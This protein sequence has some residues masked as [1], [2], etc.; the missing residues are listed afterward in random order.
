MAAPRDA[1][2]VLTAVNAVSTKPIAVFESALVEI[3]RSVSKLAPK[4][5]P[6]S[7]VIANV[8]KSTFIDWAALEPI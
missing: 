3:V 4:S 8:P 2:R 5:F 6:V 7:A 1:R